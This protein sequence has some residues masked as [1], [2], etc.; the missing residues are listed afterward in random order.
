[1]QR[2]QSSVDLSYHEEQDK[3]NTLKMREVLRELNQEIYRFVQTLTKLRNIL[4]S[5]LKETN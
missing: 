2:N 5:M 4:M 1:M 3:K